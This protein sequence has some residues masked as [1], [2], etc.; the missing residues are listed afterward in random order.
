MTTLGGETKFRFTWRD[1]SYDERWAYL[2]EL[3]YLYGPEWPSEEDEAEEEL[4]QEYWEVM[5][6][7]A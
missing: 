1:T 7:E 3:E 2:M 5:E 6:A 4:Y